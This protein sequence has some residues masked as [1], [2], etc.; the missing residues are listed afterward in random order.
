MTLN[1]YDDDGKVVKTCEAEVVEIRFGTV[2]ALM[3]LLKIEEETDGAELLRTVYTA[4]D[5]ITK[6]LNQCFPEM[7]ED[8]WDNVSVSEVV[9]V[10]IDIAKNAFT[11]MLDIPTEKNVTRE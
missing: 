10:I 9:P 6:V 8:D 3:K 7:T 4:W 5:K 1:V 2:K 11:K